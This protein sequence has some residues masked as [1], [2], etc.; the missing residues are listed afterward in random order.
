MPMKV[1]Y[2]WDNQMH[3]LSDILPVWFFPSVLT[4]LYLNHEAEPL[5]SL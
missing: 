5:I 2:V 4:D 1:E 3:L